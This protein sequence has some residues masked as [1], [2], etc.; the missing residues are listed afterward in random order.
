MQEPHSCDGH[1]H[2]TEDDDLG[3]SLR[4][5]IDFSLVTC[6]NEE[7]FNAGKS[8]LKLHEDRLSREPYLK[9]NDDDPE[10]LLHI[11][12]TESVTVKTIALRTQVPDGIEGAAPRTLKLFTNRDDLDFE[13][14][15]DMEAQATLE[16]VPPE[17]FP[18]G[19]IDY[20]LR[21]GG[22]FQNISSLTI[23][24]QDN[25][26]F[27]NDDI[28]TLLSYVGI[29]GRG[30]GQKRMAVETVYETRGMKKDHKVKGEFGSQQMI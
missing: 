20:Q 1:T 23:F 28:S 18:E 25:F 6:L 19:T 11:P 10:L 13:T 30:S 22:R 4:P 14:A 16:L 24:V 17:H 26:E 5:Q 2:D 3:Q 9:S 21:P 29:K 7:L 27:G 8:A 12:F 15:R